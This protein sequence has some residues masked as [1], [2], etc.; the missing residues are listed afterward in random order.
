VTIAG[1]TPA[2]SRLGASDRRER[3]MA[4][5]RARSRLIR[6]LRL[7]L[8]AAIIAILVVLAG[9]VALGAALAWLGD[10]RPQGQAL[11]HMTNAQFYG[12]DSG[13]RPYVLAAVEASR[14]D[15]DLKRVTLR[16]PVLTLDSDSERS[17]RISA[18]RGVYRE[19][20]RILRLNGHVVLRNAA[21]D[22][23]RTD[24]AI[25]DTV[26]G[27]V[28]GPAPVDGVGPTGSISAQ[29]FDVYDKGARVVF[30]G[31]VHSRMK[32]D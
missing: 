29:T 13:G 21:G 6:R 19:D 31:E 1:A 26:S 9:W 16:L 23:F 10:A 12:R 5:W 32:R 8:P 4:R 20:D 17:S 24:R 3:G 22:V 2:S 15:N 14:D 7:A 27:A 28:T 18:D 30:R 11:I 25:A